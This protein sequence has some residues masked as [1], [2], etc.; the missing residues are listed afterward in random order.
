MNDLTRE[1]R[2]LTADMALRLARYFHTTPQIWM[3][4]QANYELIIA[5]AH[6]QDIQ[7][8]KPR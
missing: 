8:I 7:R 6:K 3:N 2:A 1:K 5:R 4:L